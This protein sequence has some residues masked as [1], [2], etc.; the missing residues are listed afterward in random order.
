MNNTIKRRRADKNEKP[1]KSDT[2]TGVNLP[3]ER[4]QKIIAKAGL[5]SRRGAERLIREGRVR[6]NGRVVDQLGVKA[7]PVGDR[8]EVDGRPIGA[9]QEPAYYLFYKPV[10]YITSLND[11]QGRP[12]VLTFMEH[13]NV[14]L[15]PV[16][17]LDMDAEGAL[18][19]TNDGE[20]ARRLMH[21]RFHV[22]KTYRVKVRGLPSPAALEKLKNGEIMLGKTPAAPADVEV[23]KQGADRTWLQLTL[24]EGRHHQVKRMCSTI[25]HPVLKLKR[26]SFGPLTL[27]RMIPGGIR[28][29]DKSEIM[30]LKQAAGL[31][32]GR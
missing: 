17:R 20:L 28:P 3:Q 27:G 13:L 30:A 23:I 18:V 32:G 15:F 16:G 2:R 1:E 21:P 8:I 11:P 19:L 7:D 10:G 24:Y 5:A 14:R 25:G 26:Q 4:L 31:I 9:M 6:L 29:L 22:P 12:S